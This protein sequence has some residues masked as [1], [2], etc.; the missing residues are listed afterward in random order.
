MYPYNYVTRT[1]AK[2]L[3]EQVESG[4]YTS[5]LMFG[6]QWDLLLKFIEE[7][8][9]T[10]TN[11]ANKKLVKEKIEK[12]LNND[13]TNIGNYNNN[14]SNITNTNAKFSK[15]FGVNFIDCQY[16]KKSSESILLTTGANVNFSLINIYDIAGNVWK[17]T[18]EFCNASY[19]CVYRG[20]S[21]GYNGSDF[22]AK[23]RDN[24]S[25]SYSN[26]VVGFRLGLWR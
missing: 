7:K 18:K 11:D 25:T 2:K 16:L 17:W 15:D 22:P 5:G 3:A 14:L 26:S 20:G 21:C 13:S 12:E 8:T 10:K 23:Y 1:Q 4:S 19:P 9:V 6:V 24:N